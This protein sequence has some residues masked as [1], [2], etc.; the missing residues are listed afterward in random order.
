VSILMIL[1][2]LAELRT[3]VDLSCSSYRIRLGCSNG[4]RWA[5]LR[6]II[7]TSPKGGKNLAVQLLLSLVIVLLKKMPS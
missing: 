6:Q 2:D 1:V 7:S 4:N 5:K 3:N